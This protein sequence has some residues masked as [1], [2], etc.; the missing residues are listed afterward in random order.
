MSAIFFAIYTVKYE[1]Y[2]DEKEEEEIKE[3][4]HKFQ[5]DYNLRKR[6]RKSQ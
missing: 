1:N 3:I 6:V 2:N 4:D 5:H